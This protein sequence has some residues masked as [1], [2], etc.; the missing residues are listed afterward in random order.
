MLE[1][2]LGAKA[3]RVLDLE[4]QVQEEKRAS[5]TVEVENRKLRLDLD[6]SK[7]QLQSKVDE[8]QAMKEHSESIQKA[9]GETVSQYEKK[10]ERLNQKIEALIGKCG[11]P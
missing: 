10:I 6:D 11:F 4:K 3:K 2:Q 7:E 5:E 1:Q 9:G 8:I